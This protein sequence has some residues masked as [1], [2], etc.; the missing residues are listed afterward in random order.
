MEQLVQ[1]ME[2]TP[3]QA[4]GDLQQE[5]VNNA[6]VRLWRIIADQLQLWATAVDN[7]KYH[8]VEHCRYL[9]VAS[10]KIKQLHVKEKVKEIEGKFS[11]A[12][13]F[14]AIVAGPRSLLACRLGGVAHAAGAE[15]GEGRT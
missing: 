9:S 11:V 6:N 10:K 12:H 15:R 1:L 8:I 14:P 3:G 13:D 7:H 5:A 4:R 2:T